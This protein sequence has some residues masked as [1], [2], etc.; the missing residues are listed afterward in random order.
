[1]K[2]RATV[3]AWFSH[4]REGVR[5]P[6]TPAHRH[7][8]R[9]VLP[10][11]VGRVDVLRVRRAGHFLRLAPKA[12]GRAVTLLR[13]VVRA[14]DLDQGPFWHGPERAQQSADFKLSHYPVVRQNQRG[15]LAVTIATSQEL[16]AM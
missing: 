7:P 2:Y 12:D 11:D 9:E 3:A 5:Q 13:V 16:I 14:V 4:F 8:H 1:M 6:G 10:L 15:A